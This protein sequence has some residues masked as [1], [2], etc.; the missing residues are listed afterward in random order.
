MDHD[1]V[2]REKMTEKYLL[3]ELDPE[4]RDEYEEH[5]FDCPEC[6]QDIHAGSEFVSHSKVILAERPEPVLVPSPLAPP[7]GTR[8]WF[9]WFRPTLAVPVF[10]LLLAVIG[11]QNLVSF[12]QT[13]R[14]V[15]RPQIL[16]AAT[17]NLSTYGANSAPLVIH[18]GQGFLLNVIIPPGHQ[19][20]AYKLDLHN[21]AGGVESV[22]V[23]ASAALSADDTWPVRFPEINRP[24]GTYKL[25]VHAVTSSGQ[26]LE[27]GSSTFQLQVQN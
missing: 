22:P 20:A 12:P 6:A 23:P 19:Y 7:P 24:S 13:M 14:A 25:T 17:L 5:F 16:H 15:N 8:G 11:Y 27:V 26:N 21:P 1:V 2:V 4:V 9:S 18:T 3:G 10:A